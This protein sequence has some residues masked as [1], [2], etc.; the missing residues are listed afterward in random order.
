MVS[1]EVLTKRCQLPLA[2]AA[3]VTDPDRD[4]SAQDTS[5]CDG[6]DF[7]HPAEFDCR[8]VT[9]GNEIREAK[10]RGNVENLRGLG[11]ERCVQQRRDRLL[12]MLVFCHE[13][14]H[15]AR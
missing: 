6:I 7:E 15:H 8:S 13:L 5:K 9:I 14:G 3:L 12:R 2:I 4:E 11:A 1:S 10:L